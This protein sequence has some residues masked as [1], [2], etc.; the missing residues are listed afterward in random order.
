MA[1]LTKTYNLKVLF[2]TIARE[3]HTKKNGKLK[4]KNFLPYSKTVVWWKCK[5]GH[6]WQASVNKRTKNPKCPTCKRLK[7]SFLAK[8][9]KLAKEWHPTK[10]KNLTPADVTA[11]SGE[12]VW[13]QCE[14]GH[15]WLAVVKDRVYGSS[16][17][18]CNAG[19]L[20]DLNRLSIVKPELAK[21][22]HPTKNG[23]LTPDDV[24]FRSGK[25]V[26]WQCSKGH[27]W[28]TTITHRNR[29]SG[30]PYCTNRIFCKDN[31]LRT[32]YPELSKEWHP[33]KNAPM[34][35]DN[36]KSCLVKN[37]WWICKNGHV[38][39]GALTSRKAGNIC[40]QCKTESRS[41]ATTHRHISKEWHPTKNGTLRPEHITSESSINIWWLCK[42][43]HE[44]QGTI[45]AKAKK[46]HCDVCFD[47]KQR[48]TNK[49]PEIAILWHPTKNKPLKPEDVSYISPKSVWWKCKNG[50]EW[51]V[52]V[53]NL[54][55]TKASCPKCEKTE[56]TKREKTL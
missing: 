53:R 35:P 44:W 21:E 16:C 26:W 45:K 30:C 31:S 37:I 25:K 40:P 55:T 5:K 46:I 23:K 28:R 8:S 18:F 12:K 48:L 20:C 6:E 15:E 39:K 36:I 54:Y 13:W 32:L 17:P 22:W 11:K 14:N 43:G 4:P 49:H 24:T 41:F 10:N 56:R 27:G 33:T 52:T 7:N 2:P 50:H 42:N 19:K 38:W 3:W 47:E 34:T 29:G 1:N 51:K 9:P